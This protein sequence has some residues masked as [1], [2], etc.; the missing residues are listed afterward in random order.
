MNRKNTGLIHAVA[1][2]IILALAY[3]TYYALTYNKTGKNGFLSAK[4]SER[5]SKRFLQKNVRSGNDALSVK[6]GDTKLENGAANVVTAIV[7]DYRAF[8]TLGEILVLFAAVTG[9]SLVINKRKKVNLTPASEILTT[10]LPFIAY[11]IIVV[12]FYIL[13]HGHLTPGGGFPAGAVIASGFMLLFFAGKKSYNKTVLKL[14]EVFAGLGIV[15]L[16]VLGLVFNGSFLKGMFC[17]GT[18]GDLFGSYTVLLFYTLIGIKVASEILT[19]IT[20]FVQGEDE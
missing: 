19:A 15:T 20:G 10:A 7:A 6:P 3:L 14:L 9:L 11:I 2:I 5:V 16:G 17:S 1:I 12:G 4:H 8:D 13:V 18:L